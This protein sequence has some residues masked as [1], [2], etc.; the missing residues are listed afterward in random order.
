MSEDTNGVKPD[1]VDTVK[2]P[3]ADTTEVSPEG[4]GTPENVPAED[5]DDT[6]NKEDE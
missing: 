5:S 4:A 3:D 1:E 2:E 6:A